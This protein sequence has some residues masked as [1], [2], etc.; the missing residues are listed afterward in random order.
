MVLYVWQY[1]KMLFKPTHRQ[2][3]RQWGACVQNC[4]RSYTVI[5]NEDGHELAIDNEYIMSAQDLCTIDFFRPS[6]R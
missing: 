4:R 2:R 5:D 3:F 1:R 6:N